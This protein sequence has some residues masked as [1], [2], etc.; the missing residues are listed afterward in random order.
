MAC[1]TVTDECLFCF[2]Q[3]RKNMAKG[4][5]KQYVF[6]LVAVLLLT[7]CGTSAGEGAYAGASLGSVLG[8]AVGGILD[9]YRGSNLGTIVGMAAG[10]AVGG[11][12]GAKAEQARREEVHRHRE[13]MKQRRDDTGNDDT[14]YGPIENSEVTPADA[15]SNTG[16]GDDRLPDFTLPGTPDN[17]S[18]NPTT[19]VQTP[20]AVPTPSVPVQSETPILIVG[21]VH[22]NDTDGNGIINRNESCTLVFELKNGGTQPLGNLLPMVTEASGNRQITLSA[23][24]IVERILPGGTVRYTAHVLGGKRLKNGTAHLA[25]AVKQGT[26][27]LTETFQFNIPT[28][29]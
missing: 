13:E 9:G 24:V 21:N 8:S 6:P 20:Q 22:F 26:R 4:M 23:P 27:F 5:K 12:M 29:K 1:Q 19:T 3:K 17:T 10:A 15:V 18:V 28:A 11:S 2:K 14:V 7:G 16:A 25:I